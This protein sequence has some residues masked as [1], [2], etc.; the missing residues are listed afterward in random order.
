MLDVATAH[1]LADCFVVRRGRT[2]I[3]DQERGNGGLDAKFNAEVLG[4]NLDVLTNAAR[5][6]RAPQQACC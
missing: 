1:R 4:G 2:R 3:S 6:W 5:D